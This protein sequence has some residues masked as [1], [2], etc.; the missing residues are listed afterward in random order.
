[1]NTKKGKL[2]MHIVALL[3]VFLL[4]NS[5]FQNLYEEL[6]YAD[7]NNGYAISIAQSEEYEESCKNDF[8]E[9]EKVIAEEENTIEVMENEE[10]Y[11]V[12][13]V[14][15]VTNFEQLSS[16]IPDFGTRI[17]RIMNSITMTHQLII[18]QNSYITLI[19]GKSYD[20]ILNRVGTDG[21][22]L[23]FSVGGS[24][25]LGEE[26][27]PFAG[28]IV[29]SRE[30][31]PISIADSINI[32]YG[33]ALIVYGAE[34][35]NLSG[36]ALEQQNQVQ[37]HTVTGGQ[38]QTNIFGAG[39]IFTLPT[40]ALPPATMLQEQAASQLGS[41]VPIPVSAAAAGLFAPVLPSG[42]ADDGGNAG[43]EMFGNGHSEEAETAE[44]ESE[45]DSQADD[46]TSSEGG[47]GNGDNENSEEPSGQPQDEQDS[48]SQNSV[49]P[50]TGDN[51]SFLGFMIAAIGFLLS[52]G[53]LIII[54]V[55]RVNKDRG[56]A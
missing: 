39:G 24:L 47:E 12:Y 51:Q 1:M 29:F 10:L 5:F 43:G 32:E 36:Q 16:Q 30:D 46:N 33:A 27:N 17:I 38:P 31:E 15:E 42:E 53:W 8:E 21:D 22:S 45:F 9:D 35:G 11:T 41:G 34:E 19:N 40:G 14:V 28:D 50:Q 26:S 48:I 20:I 52:L 4:L 25:I 55:L 23:H 3:L 18:P 13:D 2:L 44:P 37:D 49:N 54:L 56:Q 6:E 7:E